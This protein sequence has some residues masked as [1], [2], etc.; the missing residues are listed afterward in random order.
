MGERVLQI[1]GIV[2][3]LSHT[4]VDYAL[5]KCRSSYALD[6]NVALSSMGT[7]LSHG[8]D[9]QDDILSK[10][11]GLKKTIY[12]ST[13]KE[14]LYVVKN[15]NPGKHL[16]LLIP[17]FSERFKR[18]FD[19]ENTR[20]VMNPDS[21]DSVM[22]ALEKSDR[23]A[24]D[25]IGGMRD[26]LGDYDCLLVAQAFIESNTVYSYDKHVVALCELVGVGN[27]DGKC[28]SSS[29]SGSW[30]PSTGVGYGNFVMKKP[31]K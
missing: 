29:F 20:I 5:E 22:Y 4:R 27:T 9:S 25:S 7:V 21:Y 14:M 6:A 31:R 2:D 12:K 8:R 3:S 11:D 10:L 24:A 19:N 23:K 30:E 18:A 1:G 15:G 17:E 28:L 26:M 16:D 13:I